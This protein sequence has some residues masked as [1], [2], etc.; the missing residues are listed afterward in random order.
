MSVNDRRCIPVATIFPPATLS[1]GNAPKTIASM[2]KVPQFDFTTL[3]FVAPMESTDGGDGMSLWAWS[4]PSQ[5]LQNIAIAAM[6]LGQILPITAPAPNASWTLDFWGPLLKCNDVI[7]I[8]RD[9]I[10]TNIWNSYNLDGTGPYAFLSWAPWPA[11]LLE[12]TDEASGRSPNASNRDLPFQYSNGFSSSPWQFSTGGP[13][14]LF[15]AVLPEAQRL[16]ITTSRNSTSN[17]F[18]YDWPT[19]YKYCQIPTLRTL[20]NPI[21]LDCGQGNISITPSSM[22]DDSTL[23]RCDLLNSSYSINMNYLNGVQDIQVSLTERASPHWSMAV[24]I[25]LAPIIGPYRKPR[26]VVHSS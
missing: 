7:A 22:H 16:Q 19:G 26:I 23:L 3:N 8:E 25:S 10:W 11:L 5:P 15:V 4:G 21:T 2:F 1:V 14:S 20:T 18:S 12:V 6:A 24:I 13:A 17:N 9:Q